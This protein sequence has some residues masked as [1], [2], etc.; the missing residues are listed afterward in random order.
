MNAY[1]DARFVARPAPKLAAAALSLGV[2]VV[3][4]VMLVFGVSWQTQPAAP[5]SVDLWAALPPASPP[6]RPQAVARP[7]PAKP[8]P[9]PKTA[10]PPPKAPD[11]ALE[12]K[13][14]EAVRAKQLAEEK[15]RAEAAAREKQLA[16]QKRI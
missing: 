10:E 2:H 16:E 3:F 13:K 6:P 8:A 11:I 7:E 4:V 14:A 5:V 9:A 15:A 12:R 1:A